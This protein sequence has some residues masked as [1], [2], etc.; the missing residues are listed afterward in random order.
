MASALEREREKAKK[1]AERFNT[2]YKAPAARTVAHGLMSR[3]DVLAM[4]REEAEK[5]TRGR[6][7]TSPGLG[8]RV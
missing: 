6:D 3:K 5:R 2:E 8:F 4:R 1:R 7:G